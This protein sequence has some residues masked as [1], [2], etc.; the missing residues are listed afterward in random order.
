MATSETTVITVE[1]TINAP[2]EKVWNYWTDPKHIVRWNNASDDWHTPKAEND[3]RVGGKFLSRMEAK[4][5]SFGFD[6]SGEYTA[7]DK[8]KRIEYSLG[9]ERK[10]KVIFE[11]KGN[12]TKVTERFDAENTHSV[13]M[14]QAGW[15]AILDNFKKYV[16]DSGKMETMHMEISINAG[17]EKV[18]D[19]MLDEKKFRE[20]TVDFNPTSHYKGSWEKGSKIIFLGTDEQGNVG[21]M[22][23]RIKENVPNRFVSIEHLG[24][25]QG[26]KEILSGPEIEGWAGALENYTLTERNGKTLLA[27]DVD[28]NQEYKDYFT[29]TWP[30]ALDKLKALCES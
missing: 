11:S 10:V 14:Q 22:V 8:H 30:K 15:Q 20:W 4:D 21:G 28:V 3:L 26:D 17:A 9:D 12:E 16:E 18:Y 6:F 25:I 24:I 23:S 7:V 2:V 29:E 19:T 27:V 5:G 1:A 13:E